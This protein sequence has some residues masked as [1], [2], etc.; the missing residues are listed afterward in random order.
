M[1]GHGRTEHGAR[2]VS[3]VAVLVT[4]AGGYVGSRVADR[5]RAAG[6]SVLRHGRRA[7]AT[8]SSDTRP[9]LAPWDFA[10]GALADDNPF[11]GVSAE[12]R[13]RITHIVHAAAVTRFD[14]SRE[15]AQAVNVG[16]TAKVMDLARSC[17]RIRSLGL[18]ST[19]YATG[20]LAGR[21][22]EDLAD[23][24]DGFANNYEW[25]KSQAEELVA[26]DDALP[27]RI[28]R[29]ATVVADDPSGQ[30]TQRNAFHETLKLW[31]HGL[32]PLVPGDPS[33]PLYLVT[34]KF[35][36]EAIIALMDPE[37]PGG[38]Y[39][40]APEA[41][42]CL[43]LAAAV[44]LITEAFESVETFRRRRIL[45]PLLADWESFEMLASGVGDFG[46]SLVRR[47]LQSVVP[48]ARQ[49]FVV[50]ELTND[51]LRAELGDYVAPD[52]AEL[53]RRTCGWLVANGWA[54][55]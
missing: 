10:D 3:D 12:W 17:P 47:S 27:W 18:V 2:L 44:E 38:V 48:F 42:D 41:A 5:Y 14:V 34:G 29:M 6:A 52:P 51:R 16:G 24:G 33:T 54:S 20:L 4:G 21:I 9:D 7:K 31:F 23:P 49:L 53:V 40:L 50:K 45:R 8:E 39:H 32:L 19:V 30:V 26:G 37:R 55:A 13:R 1:A 36:V 15:E 22:E 11:A 46:G 35:S 43:T 25:S 28:L